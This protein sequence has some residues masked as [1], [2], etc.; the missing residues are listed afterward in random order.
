MRFFKRSLMPASAARV[1]AFHEESGALAKLI[2]PWERVTIVQGPTS[3]A[4]GT[5]VI[6]KQWLGVIPITIESEHVSCNPGHAFVDQMLRGPFHRWVHEHRFEGINETAS[7]LVDDIEY[8]LPLE[9]LS[10]PMA[11][12]VQTRV[13]RMFIWRHDVTREAVAKAGCES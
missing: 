2:P 12:L 7:W 13:E 5:H 11:S 9:P 6:L 1:F 4:V 10:L 3:L 8:S